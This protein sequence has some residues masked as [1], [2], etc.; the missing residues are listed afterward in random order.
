VEVALVTDRAFLPWCATALRSCAEA[1]PDAAL[2][3]HVLIS[4]DVTDTERDDLIAAGSVGA[5]EVRIHVVDQD[6]VARLPS[7]GPAL[8]G[9]MSWFRIALADVLPDVGRL[10]YLDADTLVR[11]SLHELWNSI[12][13]APVAAVTNVTEPVMEPHLHSLGIEDP[14]AYF[15]AGVLV[16]DLDQWRREGLSERLMTA[17]TSRRLPWFDQ[18]ALNLVFAGRWKRLHPRWNAMNSLWGWAH[19]AQRVFPDDELGAARADPA[20]LHFEGPPFAKPWHY[21]NQHAFRD[22]YRRVLG[23]TPWRDHPLEERN[24]ATRAIARLPKDRQMA[25]YVKW[26]RANELAEGAPGAI[27]RRAINVSARARA[28]VR[29]PKVRTRVSPAE[30]MLLEGTLRLY[31]ETGEDAFAQIGAGLAAAGVDRPRRILDAASGFGRVLRYMR[32]AWPDA[33]ITALELRPGAAEFCAS[34]FGAVPVQSAVPLWSVDGVGSDFDLIWSGSFLTHVNSE[35]WEP[36]IAY[37]RDRLRPGGVL[38]FTTHGERSL[39]LL[40][41][42]PA[43][44][45]IVS[46]ACGGWTGDYG[47]A[48]AEALVE[49]VRRS[50]FAFSGY[51]TSESWGISVSSAEWVRRTVDGVGGLE[52]VRHVPQGWSEHQDVWTY[53]RSV[54]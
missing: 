6:T 16:L 45:A 2:R 1:T 32:A 52:L 36:T 33:E 14:R 10:I 25:A 22:E 4:A 9:H 34:T 35:E 53:V 11:H 26:K 49:A 17:A 13:A 15:N 3:S 19:H 39:A 43:A 8:G 54:Q 30:N 23:R 42:D 47:I 38:I 28:K 46:A 21:L 51:E 48:E 50:G 20:I 5:A 18:D 27:R 24:V 12:D 40:E 7:K 37:F 29:N 41:R 44:I 31:F